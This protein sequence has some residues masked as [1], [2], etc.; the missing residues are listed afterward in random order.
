[1]DKHNTDSV[2]HLIDEPDFIR[3]VNCIYRTAK[4][5]ITTFSDAQIKT[6]TTLLANYELEN[7][8]NSTDESL[9][10]RIHEYCDKINDD[11][12][13][14]QSINDDFE[15][16]LN[17]LVI[18][19]SKRNPD[20]TLATS[21]PEF[22]NDQY[23]KLMHAIYKTGVF[24]IEKV[25]WKVKEPGVAHLLLNEIGDL[26]HAQTDL[27]I[28]SFISN[29]CTMQKGLIPMIKQITIALK[30]KT[31]EIR[32]AQRKSQLLDE[33]K[34]TIEK[35]INGFFAKHTQTRQ[36]SRETFNRL[37]RAIDQRLR[38]RRLSDKKQIKKS[39]AKAK[40]DHKK[41]QL[42]SMLHSHAPIHNIKIPAF[43]A[44][45]IDLKREAK[46]LAS[47][48]MAYAESCDKAARSRP[49]TF[50]HLV[51]RVSS[52]DSLKIPVS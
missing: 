16:W 32:I 1:M 34:H 49:K 43:L 47:L 44:A 2:K 36:N 51:T 14:L 12:A 40:S 11:M 23:K 8:Q 27:C 21:T 33:H 45:N 15:L 5:K 30:L 37:I 10:D 18:A 24:A 41:H 42:Y 3:L 17:I 6:A 13:H 25:I 52:G 19:T 20:D 48:G 50:Q 29:L 39:K 9:R 28:P 26:I 31:N 7:F 38:H 4:E 22:E 46:R 35:H